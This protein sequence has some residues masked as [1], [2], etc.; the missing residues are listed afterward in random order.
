MGKNKMTHRTSAHKAC[1][2]VH[3]E[4]KDHVLLNERR[5]ALTEL[6]SDQSQDQLTMASALHI[7]QM[8]EER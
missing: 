7:D 8:L 4:R 1:K 3:R 5:R 6:R 2:R